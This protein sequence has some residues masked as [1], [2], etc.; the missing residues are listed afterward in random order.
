VSV[1]GH[2]PLGALVASLF[3]MVS[4]VGLVR[5]P[6]S[7][8]ALAEYADQAGAASSLLGLCG[9]VCGAAA[10]PLVGIAGERTATPLGVVALSASAG[11]AVIFIAVVLPRVRTR[12]YDPLRGRF[13][14][15]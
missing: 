6:A 11:A 8:L 10:A 7:A 14:R 13:E 2:L 3:V 5:P 4:A 9:Y 12:Q 1:L 15:K